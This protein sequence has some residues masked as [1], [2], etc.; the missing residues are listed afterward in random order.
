MNG[1]MI[2][3]YKLLQATDNVLHIFD[4]KQDFSSSV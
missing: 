4:V 2:A 1:Q 3:Y